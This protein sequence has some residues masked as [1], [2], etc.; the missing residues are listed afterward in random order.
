MDEYEYVRAVPCTEEEAA[1]MDRIY[2]E[3][4]ESVRP[5]MAVFATLWGKI[6]ASVA[7]SGGQWPAAWFPR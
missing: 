6:R 5:P 3:I 7:R 4:P 2:G 1:E